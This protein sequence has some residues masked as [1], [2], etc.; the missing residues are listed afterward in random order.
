MGLKI[1]MDIG[2]ASVGW[3][4]VND[5]MEV[6]ESASYLFDSADSSKNATRRERRGTKRLLRRKVQRLERFN[7]LWTESIGEISDAINC[8]PLVLRNSG[9]SKKLSIDEIYIVLKYF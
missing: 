6:L 2:I 4:V 9:L 7:K 1:G 3:A 5:E 8:D